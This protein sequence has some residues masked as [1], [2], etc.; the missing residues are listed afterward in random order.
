MQPLSLQTQTVYAELAERVAARD[1]ARS[2]AHLAGSFSRKRVSGRV[3]WYFKASIAGAGQREYYLGAD[4]EPLRH[5]IETHRAGRPV[6]MAEE[7][8]IEQLCAMLR[9]GGANVVDHAAARV[10]QALSS[11]GVFHLGGVLVGTY[12]YLV[13]GNVLGCRWTS[14]MRT[15]DIDIAALA[16]SLAIA[17]PPLQADVPSVLD[18]LGMGFLPVPQ[19]DPRSPSTSFKVRGRELRVD[20]LTPAS[21]RRT[22]AA[23]PIPRLKLAATPLEMLDYLIDRPVRTI[24]VDSG[25]VAV[26]VPDPARFALHKLA[27]AARRP[28]TAQAKAA[29]DR[30]Q[31]LEILELLREQRPH[32][33]GQAIRAARTRY[34]SFMTRVQRAVRTLPPTPLS[35]DLQR[36]LD[37]TRP[38]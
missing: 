9:G 32:D 37:G 13:L 7:R 11:A 33:I 27:L 1:A 18:S 15:Q 21:G 35:R 25:A 29:K 4:S 30:E 26:N 22:A 10:L 38:R 16:G 34:P 8:D 14:G 28:T 17:L 31:A 5:L 3:Y 36:R 20:F 2:V 12:A 6:E 24:A 19:L 23:I